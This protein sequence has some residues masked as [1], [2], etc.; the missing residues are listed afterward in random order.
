MKSLKNINTSVRSLIPTCFLSPTI[1]S[2]MIHR[3][4]CITETS[5]GDKHTSAE[6]NL[7]PKV[8]LFLVHLAHSPLILYHPCCPITMLCSTNSTFQDPHQADRSTNYLVHAIYRASFLPDIWNFPSVLRF[9]FFGLLFFLD[10][11]IQVIWI[12]A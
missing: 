10:C 12:L 5:L 1:L 6:E 9:I 3:N 7:R 2:P 8:H 11:W 4:T